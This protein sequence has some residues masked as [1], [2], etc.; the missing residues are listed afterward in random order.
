MAY[1]FEKNEELACECCG[2]KILSGDLIYE[3]GEA[4]IHDEC[5]YD[6]LRG[7]VGELGWRHLVY[8]DEDML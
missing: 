5:F 3:T 4:V 2:S 8:G 6:Y 1:Y 7:Y